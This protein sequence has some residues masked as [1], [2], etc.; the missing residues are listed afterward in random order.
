MYE[1]D[2]SIHHGDKLVTAGVE[3]VFSLKPESS[4]DSGYSSS[5]AKFS[6]GIS[7]ASNLPSNQTG[8]S[9]MDRTAAFIASPLRGNTDSNPGTISLSPVKLEPGLFSPF[10]NSSLSPFKDSSLSPFKLINQSPSKGAF[11][12]WDKDFIASFQENLFG[13]VTGNTSI[14]DE[15]LRSPQGKA[16][17][18]SR[19]SPLRNGG[20]AVRRLKISPENKNRKQN[21]QPLHDDVEFLCSAPVYIKEEPFTDSQVKEENMA[22]DHMYGQSLVY[23]NTN[24]LSAIDPNKMSDTPYKPKFTNRENAPI[25]KLSMRI[26]EIAGAVPTVLVQKENISENCWP[27]KEKLKFAR[28]Q[29]RETLNKAVENELEILKEQRRKKAELLKR[30]TCKEDKKSKCDSKIVVHTGGVVTKTGHKH[31]GKVSKGGKSKGKVGRKAVRKDKYPQIKMALSKPMKHEETS[32]FVHRELFPPAGFTDPGW[33]PSDDEDDDDD[34][35][36]SGPPPFFKQS[37][38]EVYRN[39][40]VD[41]SDDDWNQSGYQ[42]ET[43]SGRK[44][45][46]RKMYN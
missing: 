17:L 39:S 45:K 10:K 33:Y 28:L 1:G 8:L 37:S 32:P 13:D 18:E 4:F 43:L 34:D 7:P 12:E 3:T 5:P 16:L 35:S 27:S 14:V 25:R 21:F 22:H 36:W 46:K 44:V 41:S 15:W 11:D 42:Y 2:S 23:V 20:S 29:F 6:F 38:V 30:Q 24:T 40:I 19:N 31:G 9:T 26:P